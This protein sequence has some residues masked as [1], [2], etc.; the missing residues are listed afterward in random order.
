[1]QRGGVL[2]VQPPQQLRIR[3]HRSH[4]KDTYGRAGWFRLNRTGA[5]RVVQ[6]TT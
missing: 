6:E 5:G 4:A 1:M 2:V 3:C